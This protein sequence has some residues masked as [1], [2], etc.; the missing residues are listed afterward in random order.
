MQILRSVSGIFIPVNTSHILVLTYKR[1]IFPLAFFSFRVQE[2]RSHGERGTNDLTEFIS[3][4]QG[5]ILMSL[6]SPFNSK[7]MSLG[8]NKELLRIRFRLQ[9]IAKA[10]YFYLRI[11][12]LHKQKKSLHTLFGY[13][14]S[15]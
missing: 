12:L 13:I 8:C 4:D 7:Q 1:H 14:P 9:K 15:L 5:E 3:S 6:M 10:W 11:S 2:K